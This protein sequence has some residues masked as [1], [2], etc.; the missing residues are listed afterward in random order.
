[1]TL[2][3]FNDKIAILGA[4]GMVG[5]AIS[6]ALET[7]GFSNTLKPSHK[8]LELSDS[9]AVDNWMKQETPDVVILAAAKVGG[10]YA[11]RTYPADFLLDN[12]KIQTN[13][14]ES[15]YLHKAKRLAFLG[16]SCIYPK[17]CIQPIKEDYLLASYLEPT[18]EAY[19]IAK[20]AGLKLCEAFRRQH[21]F[22]CFSI[23]PCNL[24]G[25]NDNYHSRNSHV[26]A[27]LIRKILVAKYKNNPSIECW[28]TGSPLR[29]FLHVDDLADAVIFLLQNYENNLDQINW[30]N[31][32]SGS[33]L[34]IKSLVQ[35]IQKSAFYDQ[36][37]I[38]NHEMPDGTPQKLLDSSRITS[39]GWRPSLSLE[40]GITLTIK[41]L[42][43]SKEVLNWL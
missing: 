24:Y 17:N 23:M 43:D 25:P 33:D 10:I 7:K 12:I 8:K 36:A 41:Q 34:S 28:G 19:A 27:A 15:S 39:L 13:V 30:I 3:N 29:E 4:R 2:I 31:V 32:G 38:W 20:I 35:L 22:D 42:N 1:M 5:S 16:S 6:R 9:R 40:D 37:V 11:N 14:I 21:N 26:M 18:N